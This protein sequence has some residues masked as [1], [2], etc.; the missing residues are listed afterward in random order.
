LPI[1]IIIGNY[2][3]TYRK[4]FIVELYI[5]QDNWKIYNETKSQSSWNEYAYGEFTE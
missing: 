5:I 2:V 1:I 4:V 3:I